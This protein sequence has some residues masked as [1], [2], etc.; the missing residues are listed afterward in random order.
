MWG[1]FARLPMGKVSTD[2]LLLA[3]ASAQL[4]KEQ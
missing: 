1:V 4:L 2:S 3:G